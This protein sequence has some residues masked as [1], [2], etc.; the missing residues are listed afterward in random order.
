MHLKTY[1]MKT[2][3]LKHVLFIF[4]H[5]QV[6][7]IFDIYDISDIKV[8]TSTYEYQNWLQRHTNQT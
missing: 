4:I 5:V 3:N 6:F 7:A 8:Y 2:R 1:H